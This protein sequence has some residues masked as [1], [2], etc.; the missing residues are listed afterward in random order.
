[1]SNQPEVQ[2]NGQSGSSTS[3]Q[4]QPGNVNQGPT[5]NQIPNNQGMAQPQLNTRVQLSNNAIN[6][7]NANEAARKEAEKESQ[8]FR[9]NIGEETIINVN[10]DRTTN[11]KAKT[12]DGRLVT[13]FR[14]F[15]YDLGTNSEKQWDVFHNTS[16][17]ID[18]RVRQG[19]CTMKVKAVPNSKGNVKYEIHDLNS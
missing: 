10:P 2:N 1:M 4:I 6:I 12:S 7:L 3:N 15:F 17:D 5:T 19:I 8:F 14:Y 16:K 13:Q 9:L 11:F 18:D